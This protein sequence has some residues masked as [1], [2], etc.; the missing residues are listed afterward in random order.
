MYFS[1]NLCALVYL[2]MLH[3]VLTVHISYKQM[4]K[5]IDISSGNH[6]P[7]GY[8]KVIIYFCDIKSKV[9]A[10]LILPDALLWKWTFCHLLSR[11]C[12]TR[13]SS[14][15]WVCAW[16]CLWVK[17]WEYWSRKIG[18]FRLAERLML[19]MYLSIV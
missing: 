19:L 13:V 9:V 11:R 16:P 6:S 4:I 5:Y 2:I 10:P 14:D 7:L 8:I 17:Q 12:Q 1:W 3:S 15:W 18:N